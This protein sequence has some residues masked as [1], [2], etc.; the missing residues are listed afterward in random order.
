VLEAQGDKL[1]VELVAQGLGEYL[2]SER[3]LLRGNRVRRERTER[4]VELGRLAQRLDVRDC[5]V[6]AR[7]EGDLA[8]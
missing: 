7:S 8:P 3:A 4:L 1:V 5:V 2:V 6:D